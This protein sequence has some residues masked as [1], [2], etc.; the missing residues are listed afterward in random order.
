MY[1]PDPDNNSNPALVGSIADSNTGINE[2][3]IYKSISSDSTANSIGVDLYKPVSAV[4]I[5]AALLMLAPS[6]ALLGFIGRRHQYNFLTI[7]TDTGIEKRSSVDCRKRND[8]GVCFIFSTDPWN[9][10]NTHL[11]LICCV[12]AQS[13]NSCEKRTCSIEGNASRIC[14]KPCDPPSKHITSDEC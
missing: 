5:P 10:L 11:P 9:P 4:P 7:E 3:Q 1:D 8:H 6:L 12:P 14:S 2:A 13:L